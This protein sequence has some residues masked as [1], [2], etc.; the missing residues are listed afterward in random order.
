ML[1]PRIRDTRP[2]RG[3]SL[4]AYAV[5]LWAE[6]PTPERRGR[7]REGETGRWP[8]SASFRRR[9]TPFRPR[10]GPIVALSNTGSSRVNEARWSQLGPSSPATLSRIGLP[11]LQRERSSRLRGNDGAA[12]Y[13]SRSLVTLASPGAVGNEGLMR[14]V[15]R[16]SQRAGA[17]APALLLSLFTLTLTLFL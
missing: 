2:F 16:E 15:R 3:D 7:R 17:S 9:S 12:L 14:Q 13:V 4:A 6:R 10:F 8:Q 5:P 11:F 1:I